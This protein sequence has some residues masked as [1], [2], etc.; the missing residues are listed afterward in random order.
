MRGRQKRG[1]EQLKNS[2]FLTLEIHPDET[3]INKIQK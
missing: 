3:V 2:P 1:R